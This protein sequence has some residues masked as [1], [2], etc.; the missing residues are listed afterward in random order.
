MDQDL[1]EVLIKKTTSGEVVWKQ[2]SE[3]NALYSQVY[4]TSE[5]SHCCF[6][7][8][9]S[10]L[11]EYQPRYPVKDSI[12]ILSWYSTCE[13]TPNKY[14]QRI[15]SSSNNEDAGGNNSTDSIKRL[16]DTVYKNSN[17]YKRSKVTGIVPDL[18]KARQAL[19][20]T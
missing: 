2:T 6:L 13:N 17:A 18:S 4:P 9:G 3:D 12:Y 5:F 19:G 1:I 15:C 11:I 7:D 10:F 8:T 20:L 14:A 16:Y